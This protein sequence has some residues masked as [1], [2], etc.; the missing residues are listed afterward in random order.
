MDNNER[1]EWFEDDDYWVDFYPFMFPR[2]RIEAG[3][4]QVEKALKLTDPRGKTALDLC[5]GPGRCSIPLAKSGYAVTGVDRSSFFLEKAR[6]AAEEAGCEIE[7]V[8][9]DMRDFVRPKSFDLVLNMFTSFGYFEDKGEDQKVLENIFTSLRPGG[10]FVLDVIGKERLAKIF[11][12][13]TSTDLPDGSTLI[14]R[15]EIRSSWTRVRNEWILVRDDGRTKRY[16]FEHTIYSG[17][18]LADR[19]SLAGFSE[20]ELYGNLDGDNYGTEA[21]RLI[22]VARK[23]KS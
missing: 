9:A 10:S 7:W 2:E 14:Q 5:C 15:H 19:L 8:Q 4:E 23:P 18:E 11:Q 1:K 16:Q 22:A 20:I 21:E 17:Q 13:T 3:K 6:K 12:P